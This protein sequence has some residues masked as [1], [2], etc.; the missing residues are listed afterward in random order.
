MLIGFL[1]W[2]AKFYLAKFVLIGVMLFCA[3]LAMV[4]DE[5]VV[6]VFGLD[7]DSGM[8]VKL[9]FFL[10]IVGALFWAYDK[11]REW[12]FFLDD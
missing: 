11:Y 3:I 9:V 12:R 10:V 6:G 4:L 2:L 7:D 8:Y 1:K 5:V